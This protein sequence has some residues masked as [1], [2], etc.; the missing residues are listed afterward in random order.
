MI[1]SLQRILRLC[2][3]AVALSLWL[4]AGTAFAALNDACDAG[5]GPATGIITNTSPATCTATPIAQGAACSGNF[6]S[7]GA[8]CV[9]NEASCSASGIPGTYSNGTCNA[10]PSPVGGMSCGGNDYYNGSTCVANGTQSGSCVAPNA[11]TSG[12]CVA[13]PPDSTPPSVS[14]GLSSAAGSL[15]GSQGVVPG[16]TS[17][18]GGQQPICVNTSPFVGYGLGIVAGSSLCY[19]TAADLSGTD[20]L[21]Y[22]TNSSNSWDGLNVQDLYARGDITAV[23]TL[24]VYG[25]A[26][27]YSPNGNTGVIVVD[28]RVLSASSDGTNSS[29]VS[30]I[31]GSVTT[32]SSGGGF[33]T[34][35][36]VAPGSATT[37]S[38]NGSNVTSFAVA[39]TGT[40]TAST[41]G[42]RSASFAVDSA[43][44]TTSSN[45]GSDITS[46]VVK[47]T[48]SKTASTNGSRSASFEVDATGTTSKSVNGSLSTTVAV[49]ASGTT[50]ASTNGTRSASLVVDSTGTNTS[51]TNGSNVTS[52]AVTSTGSETDVTDGSL[53]MALDVAATGL[54]ARATDG[55]SQSTTFDV[56]RT[57]TN[58][59]ATDGTTQA[60]VKV[61]ASSVTTTAQVGTGPSPTNH[62]TVTLGTN[63][64]VNQVAAPGA[65]TQTTASTT[66]YDIKAVGAAPTYTS[67][68]TVNDQRIS[69]TTGN[70]VLATNGTSGITSGA[71]S[72]GYSV[73]QSAQSIAPNTTISDILNGR[74]YQNKINGNLLVDGNVYINGLLEYVS[75]NAAT[76]T[77]T[78]SGT[79]I[80][81]S[82][83]TTSG[84]S[85]IVMKGTDALHASVDANGK[86]TMETGVS[87]QSSTAMT[88]TNGIGNV[89]GLIVNETQAT[90]SGGVNS[91]SMTLNDNGA[92]FS[93]S[94][95]GRPVQVHGVDDGTAD[96]DA[97]NVRQFAASIAAV[98]AATS[99]PMPD[100]SKNTLVGVG[101]GHHMGKTAVA[102]GINHRMTAMSMI[103]ATIASGISRGGRP[104][105]GVGMGWGW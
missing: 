86:I 70:D 82:S 98:S 37:S 97:V 19:G 62:A 73:Y 26:Q 41:N 20:I 23:G 1:K 2:L 51:S 102:V 61:D 58:T 101:V 67:Q 56:A 40:L 85:A 36:T 71:N 53:Q 84:G 47:S 64:I 38:A 46:V 29:S 32:A 42:T 89:H 105:I 93:D 18:A 91:S 83:L 77:V 28:G 43:G 100:A 16:Y 4:P 31:P 94:A 6:Y 15:S 11:W 69:L 92:T 22:H 35:L 17:G 88:L 24:S 78:S 76:T 3:A 59:Q 27:I 14:P 96:F 66:S 44:T 80:L 45:N 12:T 8:V 49:D 68:I 79:S 52:V 72:G 81:G 33:T 104:V 30:V 13:P 60:T 90:L 25:G 57:G 95:T 65:F 48:G 21:A 7:N 9:A 74:V 34:S 39:P 54:N 10:A 75:S 50:T 5:T 55:A 103:K 99:I 87:A 63:Q